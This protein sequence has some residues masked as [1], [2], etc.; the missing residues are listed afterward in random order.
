MENAPE[1]RSVGFPSA[2]LCFP[3]RSSFAQV[4]L[5]PMSHLDMTHPVT[6][7][8]ESSSTSP[9]FHQWQLMGVF[10]TVSSSGLHYNPQ[11]LLSFWPRHTVFV[12]Q[13]HYALVLQF[14]FMCIL[15]TSSS[16]KR[17]GIVFDVLCCLPAVWP[18]KENPPKIRSMVYYKVTTRTCVLRH[19]R[20][21]LRMLVYVARGIMLI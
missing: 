9:V 6:P 4:D 18:W 20:D 19:D 12:L 16:G 2:V 15:R 21:D 7:L 3:L 10:V 1:L 13:L 8:C 5:T 11:Y 14:F 17:D